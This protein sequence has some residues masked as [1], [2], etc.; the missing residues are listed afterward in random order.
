MNIDTKTLDKIA[1]LAKLR[2]DDTD[3]SKYL[4]SF[5]KILNAMESL[6]HINTEQAL[7]EDS[8]QREGNYRQDNAHQASGRD[9][10]EKNAPKMTHGYFLVPKVIEG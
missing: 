6:S 1:N 2:I 5:N 7:P 4:D 10:V 3:K 9:I 8:W